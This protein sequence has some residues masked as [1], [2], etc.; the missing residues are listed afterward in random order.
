MYEGARVLITTDDERILR[1]KLMERILVRDCYL[2]AYKV[3]WRYAVL[4]PSAGVIFTGQP[5]IGKTTFLWF[6]LVCLLQKQQMVVM[7]M[8]ETFE[9]VLLFHVD[10]HVYTAKNARRYPR[11][12]K[13]EMKEQIFIWSLFDA[14]KDKA[15][16]PPDMVL[17]RMFPIQAPSPQYARYKEWS[18][19]RGPLITGLPLWTR[20]ELRAGVRLDPEFAQFKSY[21]DTLVGGWGINGPDAAAF[22]RYSGVLDLLRSCHA[23]PPASSDEALDALLDV[24]IDHFGYVAQ[25]VYRGMYDFDGAWMDHEVVL[26]TI[27]SEQLRSVMK[28]L[29]IELSFPKEIPKAHRLVCITPQ[30]IELRVPPRWLI[31]IKSPVLARKLVE[32]EA[33]G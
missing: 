7:R 14:G 8:D 11:V 9:D 25:D 31:D 15:A 20:D 5:G 32:R 1:R 17:T 21:L 6:L 23:S 24:L 22:E 16:A 2:E 26:Q 12:A 13:P 27:T 4:H 18:E 19:R 28:T 29:I 3:A 33:Y 30:S 10:G